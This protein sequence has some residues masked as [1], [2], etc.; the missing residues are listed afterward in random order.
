MPL[1]TIIADLL[2]FFSGTYMS[3]YNERFVGAPLHDACAVLAITHPELFEGRPAHVDI[4]VT[5]RHTRGMTLVDD[6]PFKEPLPPNVE[7]L[8]RVDSDA[9]FTLLT[10]AI[11]SYG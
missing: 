4:E 9:V 10:A 5:G 1:A 6:R 3:I 7:L 2:V 11:A 8:E